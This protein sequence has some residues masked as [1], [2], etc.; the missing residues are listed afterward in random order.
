MAS[1]AGATRSR[2]E[3]SPQPIMS[4]RKKR[5]P[6]RVAQVSKKQKVREDVQDEEGVNQKSASSDGE[7]S[8]MA[9]EPLPSPTPGEGG[10]SPPQQSTSRRLQDLEIEAARQNNPTPRAATKQL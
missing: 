7:E 10:S 9:V 3:C 5:N 4:E 2:G 8:P 6:A 1:A